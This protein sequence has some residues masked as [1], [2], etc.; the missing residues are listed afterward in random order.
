MQKNFKIQTSIKQLLTKYQFFPKVP[1]IPHIHI[2][3]N[4]SSILAT[5]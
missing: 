1:E 4:F 5:F 3:R 2:T